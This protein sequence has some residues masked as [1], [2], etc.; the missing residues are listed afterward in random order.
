VGQGKCSR[1]KIILTE[2]NSPAS[3]IRMGKGYCRACRKNRD[4]ENKDELRLL[5]IDYSRSLEGR[6]KYVKIVLKREKVDPSDMLWHPNFYAALI[7][8]LIC[9]YCLG[10]LNRTSLGLDRM[11]NKLKH[12]CYNVVPCCWTCNSWRR[13]KISYSQ[14]MRLAPLLKEFRLER[15]SLTQQ[16]IVEQ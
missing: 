14:M 2:Q 6:H 16:T 5:Q 10:P 15:Q 3:N 7:Q 11:D 9:H 8:D 13:D 4:F 1:C 12:V